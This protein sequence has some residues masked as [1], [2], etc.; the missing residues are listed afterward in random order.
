[1]AVLSCAPL[2][3][4][5]RRTAA[6][7]THMAA[8]RA[9]LLAIVGRFS[10]VLT[11]ALWWRAHVTCFGLSVTLVFASCKLDTSANIDDTENSSISCQ[12][13]F[14]FIIHL[15]HLGAT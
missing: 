7:G 1:M 13:G 11:P 14:I 10:A 4:T 5:R 6:D 15:I 9:P 3:K 2:R 8:P 12:T